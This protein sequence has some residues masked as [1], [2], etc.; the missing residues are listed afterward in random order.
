MEM[1][2]KRFVLLT[3]A[4]LLVAIARAEERN[5][6]PFS[7][8]W[9]DSATATENN[10]YVGPFGFTKEPKEGP[11]TSGVRPFV[12]FKSEPGRQEGH[13]LYPL[14]NWTTTDSVESRDIFQL[15][16]WSNITSSAGD[17]N[18][19]FEIWPFYASRQTGNPETSYRGVFPIGGT[20]KNRFGQDKIA[21]VLFPLYGKFQKKGIT[22]TTVPWPF[23]K[24]VSGDA[25]GFELW[26]IFGSRGKEGVFRETF[27]LWPFYHHN[28]R[29]LESGAT[30][31]ELAI[32][33]FYE[34]T[35][36]EFAHSKT[37][38][39]PFFGYT[40]SEQ[41][42]YDEQRWFWP[43][44]VTAKG[45]DRRVERFAPFFTYS[46]RKGMKKTWVMW[47]LVREQEW[48]ESGLDFEKT[49][50]LYFLYW[51]L[52]ERSAANPNMAPARKTH[53]WP[54]AS[55]W[56]NGA[57]H[58]QFQLFSPLEVFFQH[59]ETVRTVY[60]PLFSIYR[61]DRRASGDVHTS[62]LFNLVTYHHEGDEREF[63]LGPLLETERN[64]S[65][66]KKVTLLKVI[67]LYTRRPKTE[68]GQ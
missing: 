45:E 1:R 28:T 37:F 19:T 46:E 39:W 47:P 38:V 32:L 57:G 15:I 12:V 58:R 41:P 51:N 9:T 67:P 40:H 25:S 59:N 48:S 62:F 29:T 13:V 53:L 18:K 17:T 56:N 50:F 68:T 31:D 27:A 23:I 30:T 61:Y 34:R 10:S 7:V 8:E 16:R 54:L 65:G 42:A 26:P 4:L 55:Y 64:A 36:G 3:A 21:W 43:F 5:L 60:S 11:K 20:V 66:L 2:G 49:Q 22:T 35:R 14:F 44:I 63:N 52:E 24:V 33:P 6:W